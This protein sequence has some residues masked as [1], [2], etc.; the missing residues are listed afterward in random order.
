MARTFTPKVGHRITYY[1]TAGQRRPAKVKAVGS[2]NGGL[3][4]RVLGS[5]VDVGTASVGILRGSVGAGV[6]SNHWSPR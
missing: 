3:I 5:A 6:R 4:L 2:T 1:T